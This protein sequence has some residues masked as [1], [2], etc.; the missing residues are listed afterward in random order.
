MALLSPGVQ[1]SVIDQSNYTPAAAGSTPYLLIATAE[2]KISGAGT[3]I[4]PGTLAANANKVFL[5]TSQRD[6][7]STFGVP[8]FYNTTSGTPI[9]GYELNE[10]G[11]LA[12]YSALGVTNLAYVQRADIDLAALTATLNRP[13][14][15]PAANSYWFDTTNSTFGIKEWNQTTSAFTNKTPAVI[16]D[17]V[18]LETSSTV[19]L[20]SFG[21]IGDYAVTATS[22]YNPIYYK[23]NGP[24][25]A[26]APGWIQD[27]ASAGDLY[28][29]WV[30][31]GS[32]EW[33][34]A[35]PTIQVTVSASMT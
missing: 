10:Y 16:T 11:L 21:S 3:G 15:A 24:T 23:R 17:T 18:F 19:P 25:T 7:L 9:N 1:V 6:I 4:A 2:N 31:I 8:F 33:K 34:T 29:T 20:A 14:G 28:N 26:Q 35:W 13:V 27:G 32:D 12:G 22:V 30:L 5:M